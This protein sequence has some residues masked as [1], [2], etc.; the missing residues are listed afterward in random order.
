MLIP[1]IFCFL[2]IF[3]RLLTES[4]ISIESAMFGAIF[5]LVTSV[6]LM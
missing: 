4:L 1:F 3:L 6:G 5:N 2:F